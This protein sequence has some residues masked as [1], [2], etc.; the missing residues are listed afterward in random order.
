MDWPSNSPD[1]NLIENVFAEMEK[2]VA[3]AKPTSKQSLREAIEAAVHQLNEEAPDQVLPQPLRILPRACTA[4][5]PKRWPPH[6]L[7]ISAS[8]CHI[9]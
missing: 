7:L 3:K 2:R 6:R 4:G 5:H 1:L 9:V 8:D